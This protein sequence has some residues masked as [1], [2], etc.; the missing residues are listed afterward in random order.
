V[1]KV[2]DPYYFDCTY[3]LQAEGQ[4]VMFNGTSYI[5]GALDPGVYF[6]NP[7]KE[8]QRHYDSVHG[9]AA[10]LLAE[11]VPVP[12]VKKVKDSRYPSGAAHFRD[13]FSTSRYH[14]DY[15]LFYG[16]YRNM[17]LVH[18][19]PPGCEVIPYMSP[20]GGGFQPDGKRRNPAWDWRIWITD[21]VDQGRNVQFT[22][23]AVYKRFV[24][25][26]EIL[27]IYQQWVGS[28][29]NDSRR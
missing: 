14:R 17:V 16:R 19:F 27:K 26:A 5:N 12:K 7:Q 29:P 15:A 22:M 9:T 4:P 1:F 8:W 11:G 21:G 2:V 6:L 18:M 25:N 13:S 23:R 10:S 3:E 24:D 20:S 28:L